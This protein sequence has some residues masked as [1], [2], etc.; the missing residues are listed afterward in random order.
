MLYAKILTE[1]LQNIIN[2]YKNAMLKNKQPLWNESN[3]IM[4]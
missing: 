2:T 4:N 3:K 1:F